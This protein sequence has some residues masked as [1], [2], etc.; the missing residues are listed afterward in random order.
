MMA[1][2]PDQSVQCVVTS[3][4][5]FGL[6]DYG[7]AQWDGGDPACDHRIWGHAEGKSTPGGR[8]GS[9]PKQEVV[10]RESCRK[11]GAVR[12]D[13]QIGLEATLAEYISGMVAVFREVRRV[14]RDDG[15]L[16]LNIGDSYNAYNGGAGPSSKLSRGAQTTARPMLSTGFGL[17]EKS[18]KPKD[19]MMVPARLA[20]ALQDD[21]WWLRSDIIWAKPNPMPESVRDR[22]TSAHEHIFLLTKSA[23]YYWDAE[24]VAEPSIY[25]DDDRKS[26]SENAHK[27]LPTELTNGIRPGTAT[28]PTRN[29]RNVWK[30]ATQPFSEAHFATFPP[31][32]PRRCILAGSREGD[33]VLDPFAGAGTTLLVADRLGRNGVGIELNPEYAQM[34]RRRITNDAPLFAQIQDSEQEIPA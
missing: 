21:G 9:M 12:V 4:P 16:W 3:P 6:R 24:A 11:C 30:M 22:P 13:R 34:A 8:G 19:L 32:L 20:I 27:S 18:L 2:L 14:L 31:E 1:T 10:Q 5:Y 25:P 17:Q 7:T 28:Y 29:I 23:R 15:T 33:T 26:R